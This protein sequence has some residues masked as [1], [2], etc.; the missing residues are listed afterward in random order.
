M[1]RCS[2]VLRITAFASCTAQDEHKFYLEDSKS[3]LLL[4]PKG[5]N[6]AAA[7]AAAALSVPVATFDVPVVDGRLQVR[8][9]AP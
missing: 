3:R 1:S 2:S 8:N 9:R 4:L 6:K 5:G 7:T